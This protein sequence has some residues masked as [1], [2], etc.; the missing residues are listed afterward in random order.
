MI[1]KRAIVMGTP[2]L[3]NVCNVMIKCYCPLFCYEVYDVQKM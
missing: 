1:F 2:M 3:V